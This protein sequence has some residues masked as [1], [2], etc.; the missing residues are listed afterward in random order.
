MIWSTYRTGTPEPLAMPTPELL[1]LV[2]NGY[3]PW[4]TSSSAP[5]AP[6]NRI[7][8]PDFGRGEQQLGRV[9]DVRPQPLGVASS[10]R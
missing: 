5:C 2:T 10:T 6:S 8:L 3:V 7:R 9:A 1:L 4:S